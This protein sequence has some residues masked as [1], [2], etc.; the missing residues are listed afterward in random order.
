MVKMKV[1]RQGEEVIDL[2]WDV[3]AA[4]GFEKEPFFEVAAHEIRMLPKLEGTVHVNMAL[5]VKFMKNFFFNPG[6]YDPVPRMDGA[7]NDDGLFDQGP[8]RGLDKILFHDYNLAY[9][10]VDLPN[11]EV[12]VEQIECFREFLY[13]AGPDRDQ[14]RDIDYLLAMGEVLTLVA[15][16]Q[17]ILEGREFFD[18]E[19]ELIDEIFDFMVRDFSKFA[20]QIFSKPSSTEAQKRLCMKMI[21]SP[22]PD[23]DRFERIWKNK[24]FALKGAYQMNP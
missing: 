6:Q 23:R 9:E 4:K 15:Y 8:T 7:V 1:T 5:V 18:L 20:L 19:D 13:K 17:L 16:G 11:V 22:V 2:L 12:F 21:R 24:V 3:I 14:G 10:G